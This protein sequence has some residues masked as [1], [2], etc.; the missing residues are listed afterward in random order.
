MNIPEELEKKEHSLVFRCRV[1]RPP[2]RTSFLVVGGVE[3]TWTQARG[4]DSSVGSHVSPARRPCA[5]SAAATSGAS[6]SLTAG[7]SS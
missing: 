7:S 3:V 5:A 2:T 1:Q 4:R 6:V